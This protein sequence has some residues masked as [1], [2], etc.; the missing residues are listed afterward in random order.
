MRTQAEWVSGL[1]FQFHESVLQ[2]F[3]CKFHELSIVFLI[4]TPTPPSF[5]IWISSTFYHKNEKKGK[6][7]SWTSLHLDTIQQLLYM[8]ILFCVKISLQFVHQLWNYLSSPFNTHFLTFFIHHGSPVLCGHWIGEL[9]WPET[10]SVVGL[11]LYN[12]DHNLIVLLFF[13]I[14]L[15]SNYWIFFVPINIALQFPCLILIYF[16]C[17]DI[18]SLQFDHQFKNLLKTPFVPYTQRVLYICTY[19]IPTLASSWQIFLSRKHIWSWAHIVWIRHKRKT[20]WR[21]SVLYCIK[22]RWT[23]FIKNW[24]FQCM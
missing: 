7:N 20:Y 4:N 9:S 3:L 6:V 23:C 8:T 24:T 11:D 15:I 13:F 5:V 16:L 21:F 18:P 2:I 17:I 14:I 19:V 10:A 1:K 22:Q 12:V